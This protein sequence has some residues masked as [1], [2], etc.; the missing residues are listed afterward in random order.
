MKDIIKNLTEELVE[1]YN[2]FIVEFWTQEMEKDQSSEDR[3][4]FEYVISSWGDLKCDL[5][6][7]TP[8]ETIGETL[9]DEIEFD[10]IIY[11]FETFAVDASFEI[12]DVI[13]DILFSAPD[14][15]AEYILSVIDNMDLSINGDNE[16][17]DEENKKLC[18]FIAAVAN[19]KRLSKD[20]AKE[21][22]F[23]LFNECDKDNSSIIELVCETMVNCGLVKEMTEYID[24][25]VKISD[26]EHFILQ[27]L[28][29]ISDSEEVFKTLKACLKKECED[30]AMTVQIV[31]DCNDG[32]L[33][34]LI[35][36]IARNRLKDLYETGHTPYDESEEA[37]KFFLICNAV[38]RLG[39]SIDDLL[40]LE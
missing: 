32:R 19:L 12:P 14:A 5:L 30:I 22:L 17:N 7:K 25:C 36:K 1:S 13:T 33:I 15:A 21:R 26:K 3:K 28:V 35:R 4:T 23:R 31:S 27:E 8:K 6:G 18:V 29:R 2:K 37:K 10:D 34:P 9:P 11:M 16:I 20:I 40:S 39:G 24:L 38:V